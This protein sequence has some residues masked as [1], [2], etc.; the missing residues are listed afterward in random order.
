MNG[1]LENLS[2]NWKRLENEKI[3]NSKSSIF[4]RNNMMS[5]A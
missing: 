3:N 1:S 4:E 2:K 5:W